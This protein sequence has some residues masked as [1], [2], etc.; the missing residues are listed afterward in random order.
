MQILLNVASELLSPS[1]SLRL[2]GIHGAICEQFSLP[3]KSLQFAAFSTGNCDDYRLATRNDI[4]CACG[5]HPGR[6]NSALSQTALQIV[7]SYTSSFNLAHDYGSSTNYTGLSASCILFDAKNDEILLLSDYGS[8]PVFYAFDNRPFSGSQIPSAFTATTDPTIAVQLGYK[9]L[10][11]LSSMFA[12][13]V[14]LS[15]DAVEVSSAHSRFT[16]SPD[17]PR[18]TGGP[19][20]H[21][22]QLYSSVLNSL[23]RGWFGVN[24]VQTIV[25]EHDN[26]DAASSLLLCALEAYHSSVVSVERPALV[27][28]FNNAFNL[29]NVDVG[30]RYST[31]ATLFGLYCDS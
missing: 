19:N 20:S 4:Y 5:G 28:G 14:D 13:R 3:H 15:Q 1:F 31:I 11:A 26:N 12:L 17:R 30:G 2:S 9:D 7:D 22:L 23:R 27:R 10:N 29:K 18:S 24:G 25:V 21:A 6:S 16:N 8:T